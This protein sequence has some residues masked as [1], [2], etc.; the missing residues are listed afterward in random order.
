MSCA[1]AGCARKT[2]TRPMA[3][4]GA[5]NSAIRLKLRLKSLYFNSR[6]PV[7]ELVRK[8]GDLGQPDPE[9]AESSPISC[10]SPRAISRSP[11]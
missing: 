4:R 2:R 8:V 1:S 9:P 11:M 7:S 5:G 6:R 10:S 3:V